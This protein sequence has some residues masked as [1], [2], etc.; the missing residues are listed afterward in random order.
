MP[1]LPDPPPR[2]GTPYP[3]ALA[4]VL[5]KAPPKKG[6]SY[7][8]AVELMNNKEANR[9]MSEIHDTQRKHRW[10]TQFEQNFG[11]GAW[12]GTRASKRKEKTRRVQFKNKNNFHFPIPRKKYT[13]NVTNV[14][15]SF[16]E[17]HLDKKRKSRSML[18]KLMKHN[19]S[20][21]GSDSNSNSNSASFA[22]SNNGSPKN[23]KQSNVFNPLLERD[24]LQDQINLASKSK[25]VDRP[26]VLTDENRKHLARRRK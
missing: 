2:K 13:R 8:K 5:T 16:L 7:E 24:P 10:K 11:D 14:Y 17:D 19:Q 4:K 23:D 18:L 15:N 20:N 26:L 6:I 9:L 1:K 12:Q 3:T 25:R 22:S 21:S